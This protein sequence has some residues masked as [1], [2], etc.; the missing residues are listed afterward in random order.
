M[1]LQIEVEHLQRGQPR[2]YADHMYEARIKVTSAYGARLFEGQMKHLVRAVVHGFHE[3]DG[4]L[5]MAGHFRPKLKK[6]DRLSSRPLTDE[7]F[8]PLEEVWYVLIQE[9]F[10]D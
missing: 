6:L 4:D 1:T 5:S 8:G 9:P 7:K 3:E 10:C 2:P